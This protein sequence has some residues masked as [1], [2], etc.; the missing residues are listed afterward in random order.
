MGQDRENFNI[1]GK[2]GGH[3]SCLQATSA[4]EIAL[5]NSCAAQFD[6]FCDKCPEEVNDEGITGGG[7]KEEGDESGR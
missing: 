5:K 3:G 7:V 2:Q 4:N 6:T 1:Q